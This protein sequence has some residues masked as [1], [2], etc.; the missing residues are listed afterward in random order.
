MKLFLGYRSLA[1]FGMITAVTGATVM[2]TGCSSA[3]SGDTQ[4]QTPGMAIEKKGDT[5]LSGK[6]VQKDGK[7][8]LEATGKS[9]QEV[10]SNKVDL[11]TYVNKSVIITGQFSGITLF[12]GKI[13]VK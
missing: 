5:T 1:V 11:T 3:K 9:L 10:D 4:D 7:Y 12:A 2:F 6:L 13:E 8:Y